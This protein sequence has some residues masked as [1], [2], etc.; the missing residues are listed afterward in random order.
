MYTSKLLERT[1]SFF[2]INSSHMIDKS[3]RRWD[4]DVKL[5]SNQCSSAISL[6][7]DSADACSLDLKDKLLLTRLQAL[8]SFWGDT[9]KP[10]DGLES[11]ILEED[12]T[13]S[14]MTRLVFSDFIDDIS[15]N[16]QLELLYSRL[17]SA[18]PLGLETSNGDSTPADIASIMLS[19]EYTPSTLTDKDFKNP[20]SYSYL[21]KDGYWGCTDAGEFTRDIG[22]LCR[23][24]SAYLDAYGLDS[25]VYQINCVISLLVLSYRLRDAIASLPSLSDLNLSLSDLIGH[26]TKGA[27]NNVN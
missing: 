22:R 1:R 20:L 23:A 14:H 19:M 18:I 24:A 12:E 4:S 3:L 5:Y 17:W 11:S 16:I 6:F 13:I 7:L 27:S 8:V 25:R 21:R 15:R 10:L 9:P 26:L 2:G